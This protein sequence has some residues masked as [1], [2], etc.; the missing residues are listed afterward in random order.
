[1]KKYILLFSIVLLFT[2]CVGTQS[3]LLNRDYVSVVPGT[4]NSTESLP[5]YSCTARGKV[6]FAF[7]VNKEGTVT[8]VEFNKGVLDNCLI[9]K[10]KTWIKT[11]VKV[12]PAESVGFGLY[13]IDFK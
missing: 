5:E 2:Q 4:L 9:E 3:N 13:E 8:M 10:G 7:T 6:T 12:T 1:M 11:Y